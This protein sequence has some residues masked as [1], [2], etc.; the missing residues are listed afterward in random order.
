MK[1]TERFKTKKNPSAVFRQQLGKQKNQRF[2]ASNYSNISSYKQSKHKRILPTPEAFYSSVVEGF[3]ERD[4][5]WAWGC[6][7]FHADNNPSFCMNLVSGFYKCMSS[8]CGETGTNIVSFVGA[9]HALSRKDAISYL[10][11]SI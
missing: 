3:M 4:D 7:P 6:C 1:L 8:N 10:E 2:A 5:N 9:L 11:N